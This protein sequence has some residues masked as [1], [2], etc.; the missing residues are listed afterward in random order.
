MLYLPRKHLFFLFC[1]RVVLYLSRGLLDTWP[2]GGV[3]VHLQRGL[4]GDRCLHRPRQRGKQYSHMHSVPH[5]ILLQLPWN[6]LPEVCRRYIQRV[7]W[8]H[9][10]HRVPNL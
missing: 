6:E 4:P 9:S 2:R 3:A 10:M 8:P 1:L 5:G 7:R